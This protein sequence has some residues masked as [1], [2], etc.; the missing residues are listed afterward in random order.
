MN[1]KNVG[2]ILA[3]GIIIMFIGAGVI[4]SAVE[5]NSNLNKGTWENYKIESS[6]E[7]TEKISFVIGGGQKTFEWEPFEVHLKMGN[8]L[9]ISYTTSGLYIKK[10]T[11]VEINFFIGLAV[12][13][14]GFGYHKICGMAIG[15]INWE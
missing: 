7:Y 9:I 5:I 13:M 8:F 10:A 2:K 12:H 1:K 14:G 6:D 3:I 15:D 4:S 11:K